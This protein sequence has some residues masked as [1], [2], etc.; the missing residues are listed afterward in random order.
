MK[1]KIIKWVFGESSVQFKDDWVKKQLLSLDKGSK[2]LDAGAGEL[3]WKQYCQ[4]LQYISQDFGAYGGGGSVGLQSDTW[5]ASRNDIISDIVDI[6]V[7]NNVFDAVLCTE[8]LEHIPC[9]EKAIN[10]FSRII[11]SNGVLLIT[12][13]FCS[14]VHMAP[15]YYCSGF[16][17]FWYEYHLEKYGFEIE[18]IEQNGDFFLF[19]RQELHRTSYMCE[20]YGR[21]IGML[22]KLNLIY[23]AHWLGKESKEKND[24]GETLCFGYCVKARKR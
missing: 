12:A 4:H 20:R 22:K 10:E 18:E 11:K 2:I 23:M 21:P 5:D 19:L 9:P 14:L 13:P 3:R 15:Y 6:P 16:S 7:E 17:L 24:S 1:D 8:V